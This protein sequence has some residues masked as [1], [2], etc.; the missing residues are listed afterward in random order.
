MVQYVFTPWKDR[1]ELLEVREQFYPDLVQS[2]SSLG[3][4]RPHPPTR[5][6]RA[7]ADGQRRAV[8]RVSM[9]MQRGG[10]PHLVESTAMLVDAILA[11]EASGGSYAVRGAYSTAFGRFVTG[12]LD[13]HQDKSHKMSMYSVAKTIGL[14]ATFVELR[15]QATHE[16]LPSLTRLRAGATAGLDWIW[17]YYWKQLAPA[18]AGNDGGRDAGHVASGGQDSACRTA[19][20]RHLRHAE[21]AADS[22]SASAELRMLADR[23]GRAR[24]LRVLDAVGDEAASSIPM[25]SKLVLET[26]RL[27]RQVAGLDDLPRPDQGPS[28]ELG[29]GEDKS[30]VDAV[31]V[32]DTTALRADLERS[33]QELAEVEAL[34]KERE[35]ERAAAEGTPAGGDAEEGG[36]T[37]HEMP[38]RSKPIGVV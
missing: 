16:Q 8:S 7:R 12:L 36:W 22:S 1:R 4:Q 5:D 21:V 9:W 17:E 3:R 18:D 20:L 2:S 6:S 24:L 38:W 25:D 26:L 14:P 10:C 33:R 35:R 34:A 31:F 11:D 13:S 30:D 28:G 27:S 32:E 15:H 19:L 37:R 23:W 29:G